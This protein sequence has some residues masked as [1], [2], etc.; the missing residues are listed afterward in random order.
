MSTSAPEGK[1]D[2]AASGMMAGSKYI[3]VISVLSVVV[4][5][6]VISVAIGFVI[7]YKRRHTTNNETTETDDGYL[8][9]TPIYYTLTPNNNTSRDPD[10]TVIDDR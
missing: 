9:P 1:P 4:V 7:W 2:S 8:E 5:G 10:Y 6:F 3:V